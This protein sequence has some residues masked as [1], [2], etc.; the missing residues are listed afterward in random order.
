MEKYWSIVV[1]SG[2]ELRE[3]I[4]WPTSLES[5]V[6]RKGLKEDLP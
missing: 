3:G 5:L 2:A 1:E 4:K 6:G